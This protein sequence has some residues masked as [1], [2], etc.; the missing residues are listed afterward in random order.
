MNGLTSSSG[1]ATLPGPLAPVLPGYR[2]TPEPRRVPSRSRAA[3]S[4]RWAAF[5]AG[6]AV[7]LIVLGLL[8]YSFYQSTRPAVVPGIQDASPTA[9]SAPAEP[10]TWPMFGGNPARDRNVAGSGV[11]A[12]PALRWSYP[13]PGVETRTPVLDRGAVSATALFM[14]TNLGSILALDRA[15]GAL[16]RVTA[17]HNNR[18]GGEPGCLR[19]RNSESKR[20]KAA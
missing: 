18:Q 17:E 19:N 20:S 13:L 12:N 2:R 14:P 10:H 9:V 5:Y 1:A 6:S 3:R 11:T 4:A 7:L 15:T 8:L 16:S